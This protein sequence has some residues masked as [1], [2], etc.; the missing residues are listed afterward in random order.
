MA[1]SPIADHKEKD[2]V[3]LREYLLR[4]IR[5]PDTPRKE[6]TEA[7]KLLLRAHHALQVDRTTVKATATSGPNIEKEKQEEILDR[8]DEIINA[9]LYGRETKPS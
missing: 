3:E 4:I 5:N 6:G 9:N 1:K 8:V 2:V 7:S